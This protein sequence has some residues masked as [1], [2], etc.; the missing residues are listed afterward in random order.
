MKLDEVDFI[1]I[2]MFEFIELEIEVKLC[3]GV[4][5]WFD[6]GFIDRFCK[7]NLIL[8]LILFYIFLIYWV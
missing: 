1:E 2:V 8:L 4:V 6:I 7:E 5:L 3:Y